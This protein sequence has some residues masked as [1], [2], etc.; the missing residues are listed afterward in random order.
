MLTE[1]VGV[2]LDLSLRFQHSCAPPPLLHMILGGSKVSIQEVEG[3][4]EAG[5]PQCH[6]YEVI[7][8]AGWEFP[9]M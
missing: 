1:G 6:L 7:T 8:N 9:V 3:E 2:S 4:Q 5:L